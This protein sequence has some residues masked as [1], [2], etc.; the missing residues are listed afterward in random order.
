MMRNTDRL[1]VLYIV[2]PR[3]MTASYS[4]ERSPEAVAPLYDMS[5]ELPHVPQ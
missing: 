4:R 2:A 3:N 1:A 5:G